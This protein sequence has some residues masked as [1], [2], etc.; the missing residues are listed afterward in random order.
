MADAIPAGW[1]PNPWNDAEELY[2]S[3]ADWTG[4]S[5][6]AHRR[7][8]PD[9]IAAAQPASEVEEST[10]MRP[11]GGTFAQ[12]AADAPQ[13]ATFVPAVPASAELAPFGA[14]PTTAPYGETYAAAPVAAAPT[15]DNPYAVGPSI[16]QPYAVPDAASIRWALGNDQPVHAPNRRARF[17]LISMIVGIAAVVFAI[18]P[19]LSF[20]AWVPAFVAIAFGIVAFLGDRPRTFALAGIITG[21]AS[22]AVGTAVSIWF[23]VQL[24]TLGH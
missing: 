1:Y 19:G 6:T 9:A 18:I 4:I 24:G 8:A 17:G 14:P 13:P 11:V 16:Q 2:W 23:L 22:L 21:G 3:G 15:F 20:A 5:R 10:V 12:V 7:S